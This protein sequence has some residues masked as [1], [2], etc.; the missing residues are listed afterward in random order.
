MPKPDVLVVNDQKKSPRRNP[1]KSPRRANAGAPAAP[2]AAPPASVGT[3]RE[4][5]VATQ[6]NRKVGP[7]PQLKID[8]D[9]MDT[10]PEQIRQGLKENLGRAIDLFRACDEDESGEISK[11]EFVKALLLC[12]LDREYKEDIAAVF[13]CFDLDGSGTIEYQELSQL[14]RKSMVIKPKT[15]SRK[16][17]ITAPSEAP[18]RTP[19]HKPFP[20]S[21]EPFT[22]VDITSSNWLPLDFAFPAWEL[23]YEAFP[24]TNRGTG[25][26]AIVTLSSLEPLT[27]LV[28]PIQSRKCGLIRRFPSAVLRS[29]L[30]LGELMEAGY[31]ILAFQS[32]HPSATWADEG[33]TATSQ[34]LAALE[35]VQNHRRLRYCRITLFAQ[36]V[37]ATASYAAMDRA[38]GLFEYRMRSQVLC[39]PEDDGGSAMLHTIVPK[40]NVPTMLVVKQPRSD[41]D[42][43]SVSLWYA[44]SLQRAMRA[45][46][47]LLLAPSS[48]GGR[49][50]AG[51][52]EVAETSGLSGG[53]GG[54]SGTQPA[55]IESNM[56]MS[57]SFFQNPPLDASAFLSERPTKLLDFLYKHGG[58]IGG[59]GAGSLSSTTA[60][61]LSSPRGAMSSML[62]PRG[63]VLHSISPWSPRLP[64]VVSPRRLPPMNTQ[65]TLLSPLNMLA[66]PRVR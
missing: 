58:G 35:Y 10:L 8:P 51:A 55:M 14:I 43:S 16:M 61:P 15:K 29:R 56:E 46:C 6:A 33:E 41:V 24:G 17:R 22:L 32:H 57:M 2:S 5:V 48:G 52:P 26:L 36:G 23:V 1:A 18:E 11:R 12:G 25:K 9:N 65:A 53:R 7:L 60:S 45:P 19:R 27:E 13:D 4:G 31:S 59:G 66:S 44:Q 37:G 47:E 38:P 50:T 63:G 39:E 34:L 21:A 49:A 20:P 3:M 30:V 42:D 40:C 62:S 28:P 54:L 64:A